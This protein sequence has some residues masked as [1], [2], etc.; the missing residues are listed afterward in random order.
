NT[1]RA[2]VIPAGTDADGDS[3]YPQISGDGLSVAFQSDA[4]NL[5]AGDTNASTDVFVRQLAQPGF[6][7]R[8]IRAS[9]NAQGAQ[10]P[11]GAKSRF[12]S[13]S[14]DGSLVAFE[15]DANNLVPNDQGGFVD[16][17]VKNVFTGAIQRVSVDDN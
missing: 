13:I 6:A 15:S 16:I 17:F 8:T 2:S 14:Q 12:P 10:T 3:Q 9:V 4:T 7:A 5:V 1:V 11:N